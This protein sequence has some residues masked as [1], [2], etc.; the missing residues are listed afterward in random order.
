MKVSENF[1]VQEFVPKSLYDRFG[2]KA[3]WYVSP[4]QIEIA[5]IVRKHFGGRPMT[6]NNWSFGGILHNR[7]T[8][9]PYWG[10]TRNV[11]Q[12]KFKAAIDFSIKGVSS[13]IIYQ[14]IINNPVIFQS[15]GAIEHIDHTPTWNHI[16]CRQRIHPNEIQIVKPS[17]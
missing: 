14:E 2:D 6:I 15:I 12:H 17:K 7:G 16:D 5:E 13:Y 4:W 10:G 9:L 1:T 11:S 3:I 8:R